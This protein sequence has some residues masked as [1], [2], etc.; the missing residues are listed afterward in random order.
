MA[1]VEWT[2]RT[3]DRHLDTRH[4]ADTKRQQRPAALVHRPVEEEP[5]VDVIQSCTVAFEVLPQ[6]PGASLLLALEEELD[7]GGGRD[8]GLTKGPQHRQQGAD[9]RLVVAGRP[10][11]DAPFGIDPF[12]GLRE[13]QLRSPIINRTGVQSGRPGPIAPAAAVHRLPIIMH[14]D[15]QRTGG[16]RHGKLAVHDRRCTGNTQ[17][18]RVHSEFNQSIADVCRILV[19]PNRVRRHV[20]H[21]QQAPELVENLGTVRL[22]VGPGNINR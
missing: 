7:V 6:P 14:V 16:A 4:A 12:A 19:Y 13:R 22:A 8:P 11:I 2:H 10:G 9:W 17:Q 15:A 21:R 5:Y 1:T 18:L 3:V 20:R